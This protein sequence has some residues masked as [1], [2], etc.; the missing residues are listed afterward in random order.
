MLGYLLPK[1]GQPADSLLRATVP[2]RYEE[3]QEFRIFVPC[4]E[5]LEEIPHSEDL[6]Y[7]SWGAISQGIRS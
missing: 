3:H 1:A 2:P 7:G 6:F 5:A 4:S